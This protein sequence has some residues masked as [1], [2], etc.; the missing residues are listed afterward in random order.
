[1]R[2]VFVH[3]ENPTAMCRN[4]CE[5]FMLVES[6]LCPYDVRAHFLVF[7][8]A[9]FESEDVLIH[10]TFSLLINNSCTCFKTY[11]KSR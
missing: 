10:H 2:L 3:D 1:M 7:F 8:Y 4:C 9:V 6:K 11:Y 5:K